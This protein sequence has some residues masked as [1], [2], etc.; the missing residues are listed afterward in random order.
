MNDYPEDGYIEPPPPKRPWGLWLA[1]GVGVVYA[2]LVF[3]ALL[4]RE[5]STAPC[6]H[7]RGTGRIEYGVTGGT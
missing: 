1:V 6:P 2:V 3:G 7:C 4:Y 5:F